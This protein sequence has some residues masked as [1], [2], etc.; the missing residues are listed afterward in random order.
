LK[1]V[2]VG[3]ATDTVQQCKNYLT[4]AKDASLQQVGAVPPPPAGNDDAAPPPSADSNQLIEPEKE[5]EEQQLFSI[6]QAVENIE[7]NRF[8]AGS[9]RFAGFPPDT[10]EDDLEDDVVGSIASRQ[11]TAL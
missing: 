6:D 11:V 5:E 9:G 10:E 2:A 1:D 8:V 7:R 3:R 4:S